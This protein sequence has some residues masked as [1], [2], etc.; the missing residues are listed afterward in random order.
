MKRPFLI[1]ISFALVFA[2][3]GVA[4]WLLKPTPVITTAISEKLAPGELLLQ[5]MDASLHFSAEQ[6]NS[7]RPIC[8]EWDKKAANAGM[9]SRVRMKLFE[10][11]SPRIRQLLTTN[12]F[13]SYDQMVAEAQA[14]HQ[15]RGK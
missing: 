10:E 7:L 11:Y 12:Q 2:L 13:V 4:G 8:E 14:R 15:Q 5:R 6:K 9:R 3:G 1:F